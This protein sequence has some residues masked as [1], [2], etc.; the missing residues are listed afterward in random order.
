MLVSPGTDIS[1]L[2]RSQ[3]QAGSVLMEEGYVMLFI[4]IYMYVQLNMYTCI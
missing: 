1:Q 2:V 4:Y 3:N